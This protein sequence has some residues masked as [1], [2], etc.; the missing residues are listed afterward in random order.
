[1]ELLTVQLDGYRWALK[2]INE[3]KQIEPLTL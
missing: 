2:G 1:M 3:Q